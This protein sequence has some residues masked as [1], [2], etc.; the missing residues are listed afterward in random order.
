MALSSSISTMQAAIIRYIRA[1][2]PKDPNRAHI[3]TINGNRVVIGN[4]SYAYDP[5]VDIFFQNG[6]KVY[7]LL[8]NGSNV[9]AIVGVA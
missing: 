1:N 4:K 7:C 9:A 8:P 2:I 5:A 6:D 3:G